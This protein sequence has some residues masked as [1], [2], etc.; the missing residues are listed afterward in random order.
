MA[1]AVRSVA[2]PPKATPTAGAK[3]HRDRAR[4]V[5]AVVAVNAVVVVGLWVRHG[6]LDT[7][8]HRVASFNGSRT[9]HGPRRHLR[10]VDRAAAHVAYRVARALR[11]GST[12]S[13]SGIDGP[14]SQPSAS[15]SG[16]VVFIT[17]GYAAGS[18]QSMLAQTVD[19]VRHYPDV[20]MSIVG[21]R[22]VPGCRRRPPCA[23]PGDGCPVRP[24]TPCTSTRISRSRS[25]FAH[26]LAVGHGLQQRRPGT[27]LVDRALRRRGRRHCRVAGRTSD[28]VQRSTPTAH[29]LGPTGG[30]RRRVPRSTRRRHLDEVTPSPASSSS[31]GSSPGRAGQRPTRSRSRRRRMTGSSGSR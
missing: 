11:S 28:V 20:L 6:G 21:L 27:G 24:G 5:G 26:Q 25:S 4:D 31:G 15:C 14:G 23:P 9:A 19:F 13:R 3:A 29:R 18:S 8:T 12:V 17:L 7:S 16:H 2:L 30:E 1:T 10:R 22:A